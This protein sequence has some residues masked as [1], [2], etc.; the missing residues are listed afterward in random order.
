MNNN[1]KKKKYSPRCLCLR[2]SEK[3]GKGGVCLIHLRFVLN[4]K[5]LCREL[6]HLAT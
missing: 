2:K 1:N 3:E 6:R 4:L 5:R